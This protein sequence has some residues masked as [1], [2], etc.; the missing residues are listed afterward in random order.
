M[1]DVGSSHIAR[2]ENSVAI[3]GADGGIVLRASSARADHPKISGA[4][5]P[6]TPQQGEKQRHSKT[7]DHL[8]VSCS[9]DMLLSFTFRQKSANVNSGIRP[10]PRTPTCLRTSGRVSVLVPA[11]QCGSVSTRALLM[12]TRSRPAMA[13]C[14]VK[15]DISDTDPILHE[16]VLDVPFVKGKLR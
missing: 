16:K 11:S 3:V 14:S 4:L 13:N 2:N 15:M 5:R 1:G 8:T 12:S 7:R 6:T 9:F 10:W